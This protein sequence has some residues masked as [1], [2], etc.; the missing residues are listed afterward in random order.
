MDFYA[1]ATYLTAPHS[2]STRVGSILGHNVSLESVRDEFVA[3]A[4]L[5]RWSAEVEIARDETEWFL[6]R[7]PRVAAR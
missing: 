7:F 4:A 2:G 1:S 5:P 3:A 6:V